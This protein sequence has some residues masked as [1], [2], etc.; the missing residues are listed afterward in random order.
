MSHIVKSNDDLLLVKDIFDGFRKEEVSVGLLEEAV[1][2]LLPK[3]QNGEIFSGYELCNIG[4]VP[5]SF[6]FSDN[7]LR[8]SIDEMYRWRDVNCKKFYERFDIK[9][10]SLFKDYI[11]LVIIIHEIEHVYQYL[12]AY[13]V[14]DSGCKLVDD[15]YKLIINTL[16]GRGYE[17][18]SLVKNIRNELA[19]NL[20]F[21]N[22]ERYVIERN[23]NVEAFDLLQ[24]LAILNGHDELARVFNEIRNSI[25]IWGYLKDN[26][27]SF[28]ETCKEMLI[29]NEY[30]K[31]DHN[32]ELSEIDRFRYGLPISVDLWNSIRIVKRKKK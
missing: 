31:L 2:N 22:S 32:Y 30:K 25:G 11:F 21:K 7:T 29:G 26:R 20:Y 28:Y 9:D 27:G 3:N 8:L 1:L 5:S 23:A 6:S 17:N 13:G 14:I 12:M 19:Y 15:G 18:L 4:E 16:L 10:V 24:Q